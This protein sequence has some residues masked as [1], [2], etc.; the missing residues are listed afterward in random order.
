MEELKPC[1]FCGR[2]AIVRR[3]GGEKDHIC[4]GIIGDSRDKRIDGF[5]YYWAVY[6]KKCVASTY[7]Y[8]QFFSVD[9]DS[10][11]IVLYEDGRK[12][13]I[14]AWNSRVKVA[15]KIDE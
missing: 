14:D 12:N 11:K 4:F 10:G 9:E 7:L 3:K 8:R 15:E 2:E 1:P 13:A 5:S 6:C